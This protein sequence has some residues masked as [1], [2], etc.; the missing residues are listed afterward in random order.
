DALLDDRLALVSGDQARRGNDLSSSLGLCS[1]Q[2]QVDDEVGIEQGHGEGARG[3]LRRQVDHVARCRLPELNADSRIVR[4]WENHDAVFELEISA[5]DHTLTVAASDIRRRRVD[6]ETN[7]DVATEVV[8]HDDDARFD[9]DLANGDVERGNQPANVGEALGRILQEQRIRTLVDRDAA[10][11]REQGIVR[12]GLD[13]RGQVARLRVV[14]LQVLGAQRRELLRFRASGQQLALARGDFRCR[15]DVHDVAVATHVETLRAHDDVERLIPGY[16]LQ[17]QRHVAADRIADDH[18]LAARVGEKLEHRAGFNVL[19]VERQ[20]LARVLALLL[21]LGRQL[22][23]RL[24]LDCVN[25]VRLL[26]EL[27]IVARGGD[28]ESRS[29]GNTH[30]IYGR[31]GRSE[32]RDVEALHEGFGQARLREVHD[33]ATAFLTKIGGNTRV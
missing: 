12:A 6:A 33:D 8:V 11:L 23:D 3:I 24:D 32:V 15:R 20:A 25:V 18:I 21:K 7:T 31:H 13:Q 29:I 9:H 5:A 28:D 30:R 10:A 16:V 17:T 2:L 22:H 26:R 14:H 1:R 4:T 27:L 19:E